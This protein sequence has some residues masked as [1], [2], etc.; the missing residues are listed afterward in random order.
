VTDADGLSSSVWYNYDFGAKMRT[1]GP[2]PQNQSQGIIQTF[3]YDEAMRVKQ[4]TTVNTGAY[5]HYDYGLDYTSS[6]ASVN[7]VAANYWESDSYTNRFFDGLGRVFAAASNH[8]G[9]AGGYK[10]QWIEYDV[11]GRV[12]RQSN[13]TEISGDGDW[14]PYGDDAAGRIYTRQTYDWKG[15]PLQTIHETDGTVKSASY[16]GCGCAGGEVVTLTDEVGRQQKVY[17][18]VLGRQWKTEVL[19]WDSSVYATTTNAFNTRDQAT[20]VRQFQGTDQSGVYQ[21]TIM[22][23]DG[24]GRLAAK[25]VPEQN[26]GANTI[27]AYNAD[28]TVSSVTDAR[29]VATTFGYNGRHLVTSINYP[30]VQNLPAGVASIANVSFG[31][32]AVGNRI[33]MSDGLGSMSYSY[34]QLSRLS[35]ETRYFSALGNSPTGGNYGISYQ[36]N[37]ANELTSV[38]DPFGAQMSY[39]R[40]TAG[41]V[42]SVTGSGFLN[43]SS[44]ASNIQYRAGGGQKSVTYGD[45]TSSTTS[46]NS[47]MQPSSYQLPGLR[48]QFQYYDDG[49]LQQMTDLDDRG[50]EIGL[51]DTARHF[52]RAQSYDQVGRLVSATG[53]SGLPYNQGYSYDEFGNATSRGGSY[54]YQG[55]SSDGGTFQNNR[56]QD[57]N[58]DANGNVT[59]TPS[60][61]YA[62]GSVLS[63]RDWTYDA[64][65]QMAQVRETVTANNSVSTYISNNDGDGQPVIECYQENLATKSFMVR[66][67]V[68]GGNVLTRLDSAGNKSST[69]FNVDGLLTVVQNGNSS[70]SS[71]RWTHIDP[72]GL[73]EAGDTKAVFDP[74]GNYIQWQHAP[75]APPNAYPPI[76]ASYGGLGPSFGYAIN[77]ACILDGIPTDCS[78][79]LNMLEHG[80]AE[81]CPNNYCGAGRARNGDL[82][83]LTR[84]PDTGLLGYYSLP[85]QNS[86]LD[87]H[88]RSGKFLDCARK[89]GLGWLLTEDAWKNGH[90]FNDANASFINR[91]SDASA[92]NAALLGFTF[93]H[94]GRFDQQA[95][96]NTNNSQDRG[97]WDFGPFQLNYYQT[98]RDSFKGKSGDYSVAG[99]DLDAA[100]GRLGTATLNPFENG[101]LAGRKLSWLVSGARGDL[102]T[103]AG[104]FQSWTGSDFTSRRDSWKTEGSQFQNFFDCFRDR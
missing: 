74:M 92:V 1:Q 62:G 86:T 2:P 82:R 104:R 55:Y 17:S 7:S 56:R 39:N 19:N 99:I 14:T 47:R 87:T 80:S 73:S 25:H 43:I 89:A 42:T 30:A 81:Q 38:T 85:P 70:S 52:S 91:L 67:S 53:N 58:Y 34:D 102:A 69:A 46:Y 65:G 32:D 75:T 90:R 97:N 28:N 29:G 4:V 35:S 54:Y 21:D 9:S 71:V 48:E 101:R 31:Y 100:F 44:Y 15:R 5:V 45:G 13:P 50:Q 37:L 20:L 68:L 3:S 66:S 51:P 61:N 41:R 22:S 23:Y 16:T 24:Y 96:P 64:A 93:D 10:A 98:V 60:Y 103:A 26:A 84:D 27:Y 94:E 63:F 72:L 88:G 79:A 83:P 76:A 8:P 11:M 33:S 49:R 40:D 77:S 59:H 6:F 57:L 12:S 18:D 78:L 95:S 36:Y